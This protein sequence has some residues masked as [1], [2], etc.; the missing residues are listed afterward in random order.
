VRRETIVESTTA[1]LELTEAEANELAR[2]GKQLASRSDWWG[3]S[4]SE[5][6]EEELPERTVIR[7]SPTGGGKWNVRVADAVGH[8]AIGAL[9]IAVHPK[10]PLE[11][12]L[13]LFEHAR[14]LPRTSEERAAVAPEAGFWELVA[15]W[16]LREA[17]RLLR[18]DL[19][20]DYHHVQEVLLLIRGRLEPGH[21]SAAFLQ[22]RRL[23]RPGKACGTG[24]R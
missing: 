11:H 21:R 19:I 5:D 2:V 22:T 13:Y 14:R 20:R 3:N 17:E 6:D 10:I 8:I 23:V 7:V 12:L 1:E 18:R 16:Y 4:L 24:A 9:Q 15:E